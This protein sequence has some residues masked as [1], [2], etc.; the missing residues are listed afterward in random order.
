MNRTGHS[1]A[2]SLCRLLDARESCLP[3]DDA[4]VVDDRQSEE[5]CRGLLSKLAWRVPR[6]WDRRSRCAP[7]RRVAPSRSFPRSSRAPAAQSASPSETKSAAVRPHRK[8]GNAPLA[9]MSPSSHPVGI[10]SARNKSGMTIALAIRRDKFGGEA[11]AGGKRSSPGGI[12]AQTTRV[13]PQPPGRAVGRRSLHSR[14]P[15]LP[16]VPARPWQGPRP[17]GLS[18]PGLLSIREHQFPTLVAPMT[19]AAS[20]RRPPRGAG[21]R[22]YP[23]DD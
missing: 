18:D 14:P 3:S 7:R 12:W 11:R 13:L 5:S 4:P 1:P 22:G 2:G 16:F 10:S 9:L 15:P 21:A 17:G 23:S 6:R 19:T 20:Y 8:N